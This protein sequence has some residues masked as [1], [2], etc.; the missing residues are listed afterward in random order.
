MSVKDVIKNSVFE[1]IGAGNGL[2]IRTV[3][4]ILIMACLAV[5]YIFMVYKLSAKSAFYSKDLNITMAGMP[6]IV[7]AI[8]IAMQ[9]NLLVSL[10]MVGALSI[11]RFRNAVK[12]PVDLLYLFWSISTGIIVGVGIHILGII[13]CVIMTILLF[14]LNMIPNV[15]APELLVLRSIEKEMNYEELYEI[16]RGN[17][18]YFKEKARTVKNGESEIIIEISTKSK[19]KLL[20]ELNDM[21]Q[22]TQINCLSHDGECRI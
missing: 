8:M 10:G 18:K 12:N 2:T 21:G 14:M 1:S 19:E 15:K 3:L 11:V 13:L 6:V 20:R 7:A 9:S 16:I 17:C 5:I 4:L 22:L